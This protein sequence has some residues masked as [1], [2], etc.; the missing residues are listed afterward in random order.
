MTQ[1][2]MILS[3]REILGDDAN[4]ASDELLAIYL[5]EA[6]N[7]IFRKVYPF[8]TTEET[9]PS[10]YISRQI[11]IATYLFTKNGAEGETMHTEG[12]TTRMYEKGGIPPSLLEG[13]T[14]FCGMWSEDSSSSS[15]VEDD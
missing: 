4:D 13:I 7:A 15:A 9:I 14:S 8:T 3:L 6:H 5:T 11:E 2:E 12:Q 10:K 1:E